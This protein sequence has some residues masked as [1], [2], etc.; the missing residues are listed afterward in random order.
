MAARRDMSKSVARLTENLF[1]W[2]R[3][4][5]GCSGPFVIITVREELCDSSKDGVGEDDGVE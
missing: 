4:V 2:C 3:G 1:C 5:Y